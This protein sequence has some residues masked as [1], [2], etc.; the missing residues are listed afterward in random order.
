MRKHCSMDGAE[1]LEKNTTVTHEYV[2]ILDVGV[3]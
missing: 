2:A 1:V 3:P